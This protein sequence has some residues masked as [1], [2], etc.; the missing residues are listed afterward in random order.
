[1]KPG[2]LSAQYLPSARWGETVPVMVQ[3]LILRSLQQ[4]EALRYVGREPLGL[5]GDVAVVTDVIDFQAETAPDADTAE[6]K[7]RLSVQ[8]VREQDIRIL[9]SRTFTATAPSASL[10]NA[11]VVAAFDAAS[12]SMMRDITDWIVGGLR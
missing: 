6:V 7:L 11:D 1:I 9:A 4:T 2:A 3:S 12:D 8:L 5:S 10:D